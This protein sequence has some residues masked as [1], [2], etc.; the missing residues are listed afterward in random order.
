ME[1]HDQKETHYFTFGSNHTHPLGG[2]PMKDYWVEIYGTDD[3]ARD[4]MFE[5]YGAKWSM[6]YS[7]GD[8]DPSWFPKGCHERIEIE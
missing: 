4:K 2:Y 8:F 5:V 1:R 7:E 3:E 6:Q